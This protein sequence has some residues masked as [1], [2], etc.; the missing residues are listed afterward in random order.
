MRIPDRINRFLQVAERWG[1]E[2]REIITPPKAT[3]HAMRVFHP[4]AHGMPEL[5]IYWG[6]GRAARRIEWV[7]RYPFAHNAK[8]VFI[9]DAYGW[10][11]DVYEYGNQKGWRPVPR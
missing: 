4:Q 8:R 3:T 9:T 1:F 11:R 10:I 5:F 2:H 6:P 7:I